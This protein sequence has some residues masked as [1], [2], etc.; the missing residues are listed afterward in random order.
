MKQSSKRSQPSYRDTVRLWQ[1]S[2]IALAM[3]PTLIRTMQRSRL[4]A[5]LSTR[6]VGGRDGPEATRRAKAL[7]AQGLRS[8]MFFLGEYVSDPVLIERSVVELVAL[9]PLL[10]AEG[11]EAHLSIDPTQAGAMLDWSLCQ[12]NVLRVAQALVSHPTATRRVLMLDMEDSSV[13]QRTIDLHDELRARGLPSA[14]TIQ[15]SLRRS[16]GDVAHLVREGAMVRLVKGALAE[17]AE[18]AHTARG[19]IDGSYRSLT[20]R[21]LGSEAKA[22]GVSP[23]FGTH[24]ERLIDH[25]RRVAADQGWRPDQWEVEMLLGVRPALQRKLVA[26]GVAVRLYVPFGERFWPYSIRRV[27]ENPRNLPFVLNALRPT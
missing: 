14:V 8:S 21:L 2:M 18:V 12:A 16:E 4:M 9:I 19:D 22:Q 15:A 1:K 5:R 27:G 11:L 3:S 7:Q 10:V 13:T 6:F 26:E 23:V 17:P 20:E 25:A 24:D